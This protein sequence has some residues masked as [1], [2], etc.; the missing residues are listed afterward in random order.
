MHNSGTQDYPLKVVCGIWI[1]QKKILVARRAPT[2]SD[3]GTW[4]FP[5]GKIAVGETPEVALIREWKEE[6]N[7]AITVHEH[8]H[9]VIYEQLNLIAFRVSGVPLPTHSTDHDLIVWSPLPLLNS[10]KLGRADSQL[11]DFLAIQED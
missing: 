1:R 3:S 9:S 2:K 11:L 4:E 8:I 6:L 7:V 10:I 5:G